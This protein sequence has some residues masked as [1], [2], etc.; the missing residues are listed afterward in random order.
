MTVKNEFLRIMKSQEEMALATSVDNQPNLRV[1]N[2]YFDPESNTLYF[3]TF[4][5][6][7]KVKEIEANFRVAF[8][9]IPHAGTEHVKARGIAEKS[10]LTIFDLAARFIKKMPH[11]EETI[12]QA[13]EFLVLYEIKFNTATVTL[14]LD[15]SEDITF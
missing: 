14:D 4:G 10:K 13:G 9:T 6:N 5:N 15:N 7:N 2:F 11:Y 12:E 1:V 8:T 3:S